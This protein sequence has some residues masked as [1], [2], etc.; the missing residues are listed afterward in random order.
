MVTVSL[1]VNLLQYYF[2]NCLIPGSTYTKHF[3]LSEVDV[4]VGGN[5]GAASGFPLWLYACGCFIFL[6]ISFVVLFILVEI[7]FSLLFE[8]STFWTLELAAV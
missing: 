7:G 6:L 5:S 2:P 8:Y 1:L 3:G 4:I